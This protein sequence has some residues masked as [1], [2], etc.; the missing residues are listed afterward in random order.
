MKMF[1]EAGRGVG[2]KANKGAGVAVGA[3]TVEE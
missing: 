2:I 3:Y 1:T